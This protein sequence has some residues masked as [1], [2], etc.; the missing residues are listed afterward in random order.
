[1]ANIKKYILNCIKSLDPTIFICTTLLSL[2]SIV[3]AL[4]D[5]K[6]RD[7][8]ELMVAMRAKRTDAVRGEC[9]IS[10]ILLIFVSESLY[11]R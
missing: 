8:S 4:V 3:N 5:R 10:R 1:M 11:N 7:L 2:I 6:A 9:R